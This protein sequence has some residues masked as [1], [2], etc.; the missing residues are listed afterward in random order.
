MDKVG[1]PLKYETPDSLSAVIEEYFASTPI[2]HYTVTGLA[3]KVGG[4]QLLND[5]EKRDGFDQ[6]VRFAKLRIE[7]AYELDL[8]GSKSPT[9]AIFALKNFGWSDKQEIEQS[10]NMNININRIVKE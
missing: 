8:R 7:N 4:K 6:I 1:R 5:Y 2:E 3:M 10:G 9:G